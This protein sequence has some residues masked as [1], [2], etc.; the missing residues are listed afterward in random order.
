MNK[1]KP[2]IIFLIIVLAFGLIQLN[3]AIA[4]T[5]GETVT[6]ALEKETINLTAPFVITRATM[7]RDGGTI[8]IIIEDSQKNI[9]PIC[10]DGR[11]KIPEAQRYL[12]ANAVHPDETN[13]K[14]LAG[15]D[16]EK[17]ILNIL[18]SAKIVSVGTD[19]ENLVRAVIEKIENK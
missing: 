19:V 1:V 3:A 13:N 16:T 6:I 7:Y 2:G 17:S 5:D 8:S 10:L 18:K 9:F 4:F 12:Y 15:S 11:A 14:V